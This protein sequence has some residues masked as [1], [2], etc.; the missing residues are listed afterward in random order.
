MFFRVVLI[1]FLCQCL[2]TS[3][4]LGLGGVAVKPA[5]I[6]ICFQSRVLARAITSALYTVERVKLIS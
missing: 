3:N 5:P 1:S 2:I 6:T 4:L